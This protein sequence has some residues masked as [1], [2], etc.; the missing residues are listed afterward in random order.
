M[1]IP[2]DITYPHRAVRPTR[3]QRRM[4]WLLYQLLCTHHSFQTMLSA[5]HDLIER[6]YAPPSIPVQPE[7]S[8]FRSLAPEEDPVRCLASFSHALGVAERLTLRNATTEH[9]LGFGGINVVLCAIAHHLNTGVPPTGPGDDALHW[10]MYVAR[11][12]AKGGWHSIGPNRPAPLTRRVVDGLW[13]KNGPALQDPNRHDLAIVD[14]SSFP[15]DE[16]FMAYVNLELPAIYRQHRR[17]RDK[18]FA[19]ES[20]AMMRQLETTYEQDSSGDDPLVWEGREGEAPPLVW[21][22]EK[23]ELD[24]QTDAEISVEGTLQRIR[25]ARDRDPRNP[26]SAAWFGGMRKRLP[27]NRPMELPRFRRALMYWYRE[28]LRGQTP[29]QQA[30]GLS[31]K[32]GEQ[33]PRQR[34]VTRDLRAVKRLFDE[35]D[36][37]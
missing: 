20:D 23:G 28:R 31:A 37:R 35:I 30:K 16:I 7:E 10:T 9:V 3:S 34:D 25:E 36:A 21:D 24:F 32:H 6:G 13:D 4:A 33:A 15:D 17:D 29:Y 18:W 12:D 19:A 22:E 11:P 26:Y 5:L 8:P 2:D 27:R 14:L 1:N